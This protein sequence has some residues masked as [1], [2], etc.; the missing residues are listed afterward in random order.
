MNR[1]LSCNKHR[2]AIGLLTGALLY[3]ASTMNGNP[4]VD[5]DFGFGSLPKVTAP[6]GPSA[7]FLELA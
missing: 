3:W 2:F 6:S 5:L 1:F 7:L 4:L